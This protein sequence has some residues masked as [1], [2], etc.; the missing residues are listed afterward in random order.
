[1]NITIEHWLPQKKADSLSAPEVIH[2]IG[3]LL[4]ISSTLNSILGHSLPSEKV[5]KI[6]GST[7][8]LNEVRNFPIVHEFID[9]YKENHGSWTDEVIFSLADHLADEAYR[10]IWKFE[11]PI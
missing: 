10:K 9:A 5:E 1:M 3:N 7:S 2:N 11:P 4:L 8:N 6:H